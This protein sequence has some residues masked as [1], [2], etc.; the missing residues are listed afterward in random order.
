MER[1]T[2][3]LLITTEQTASSGSCS[4]FYTGDAWFIFRPGPRLFHLCIC[5]VIRS[6]YTYAT[7][8]FLVVMIAFSHVFSS[9]IFIYRPILQLWTA[10]FDTE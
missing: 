3:S 1:V 9:E 5:Y 4:A 2:L 10:S 8:A 7:A 6:I